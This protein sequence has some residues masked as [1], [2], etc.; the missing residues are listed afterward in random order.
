MDIEFI[1]DRATYRAKS[2]TI[3]GEL[4]L[5]EQ[6]PSSLLTGPEARELEA[7]ARLDDLDVEW[8]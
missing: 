3:E 2:H 7:Q 6:K 8:S 5:V 1:K 4:W